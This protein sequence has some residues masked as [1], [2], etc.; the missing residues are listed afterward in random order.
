[1][2]GPNAP[3]SAYFAGP[4]AA[5]L[6]AVGALVLMYA[7]NMTVLGGQNTVVMMA[8][9]QLF[10]IGLHTFAWARGPRITYGARSVLVVLALLGPLYTLLVFALYVFTATQ[11]SVLQAIPLVLVVGCLVCMGFALRRP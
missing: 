9:V 11:Q 7:Q 10:A 6:I 5:H 3:Q 2:T 8:I 1:M 4:L